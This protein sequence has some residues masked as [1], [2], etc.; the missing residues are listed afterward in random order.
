MEF[1]IVPMTKEFATEILSWKYPSPYDLY[2]NEFSAAAFSELMEGSYQGVVNDFNDLTGFFCTG[3]T[4]KVP[5][6]IPLGVYEELAVDFGLG[7]RPDLTGNGFGKIFLGVVLDEINLNFPSMKL[8]LT[9]ASFNKRAIS[10][11]KSMGFEIENQFKS[12][13]RTFLTMVRNL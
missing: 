2:N 7:M 9:V 5:A 10:V 13:K 6:G 11:Y 12:N 3:D 8:R 4:A 1:K